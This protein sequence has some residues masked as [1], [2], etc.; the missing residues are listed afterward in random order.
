M[1]AKKGAKWVKIQG[2]KKAVEAGAE[3]EEVA[4]AGKGGSMAAKEARVP[5]EVMVGEEAAATAGVAVE[6]AVEVGTVVAVELGQPLTLQLSRW[7][8]DLT[9]SSSEQP[10]RQNPLPTKTLAPGGCLSGPIPWCVPKEEKYIQHPTSQA[11]R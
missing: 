2:E 11:P 6:V 5:R 10:P 7:S 4:V 9:S 1:G 3:V 8:R